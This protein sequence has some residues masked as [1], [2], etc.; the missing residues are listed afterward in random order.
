ML[1][2]GLAGCIDFPGL[3]EPQS[4]LPSIPALNAGAAGSVVYVK[5]D[6]VWIARPDG[7]SARQ[8]THDGSTT[9]YHDPVQAPDGT[10]YALRG[11]NALYALDRKTGAPMGSPIALAALENGAASLVIA[12]DGAHIAY[13]TTGS[14][15][16]VDPRF[17]TPSGASPYGGTDV[18][19]LDGASVPGAAL[20]AMTY[21]SW[22]DS[23]TLAVSD[24]IKLWVA[25]VG[26]QPQLW[27]DKSNGCLVEDNCPPAED[28]AANLSE[29]VI[30]RD[31]R[32]AAYNYKP[33][34]G[35][36]ARLLSTVVTHPPAAPTERCAL[37]NQQNYSDPGS[38]AP[39]GSGFAYDDTSFDPAT[40][41][42]TV[43]QGIYLMAVNLRAA[44][45]GL[46]AAA[47]V[48]PGGAQP[49]WGPL[50]P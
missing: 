5:G 50:A 26:S 17:G 12:P 37:P 7:T 40:L 2:A 44:D 16:T 10:I 30:S 14:G 49:D 29:P 6:D 15:T 11:A 3:V 20:A 24:G 23:S 48:I 21:P 42:T 4:G 13:V 43:G 19:T 8:L 36:G 25:T 28:P 47:L 35:T 27:V 22:F 9:T 32:L 45:C 31:G 41:V 38:F 1:A 46:T 34:F 18:A 39:N 33:Y